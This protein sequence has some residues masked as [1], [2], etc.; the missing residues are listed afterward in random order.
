MDDLIVFAHRGASGYEPENTLAAFEKAIELGAKWIELDVFQVENE[1]LVI[2]DERLERTTNGSGYVIEKSVKYL[3][4][5]DA[6]NGEKIPFLEEV[7]ELVKG[8]AGIN[9]ELKGTSSASGIVTLVDKYIKN[10]SI[11]Y[12]Q[13]IVSSF[14]HHII[15]KTKVLQP[16]IQIAPVLSG[17]PLH[18]GRFAE[19]LGAYSVHLD[20]EFVSTKFVED[21]QA[22]GHKVFVFTVNTIENIEKAIAMKIDGIF[23]NFPDLIFK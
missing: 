9:I 15:K 3:R 19:D 23:T 14:N 18:Y 13:I 16:K 20:F 11:T 1:F 10:L 17:C 12:N 6:G 7:F 21:I 8:R 22:R 5:L 2:H 4:S